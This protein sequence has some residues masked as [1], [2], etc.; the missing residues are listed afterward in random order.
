MRKMRRQ[1]ISDVTARAPSLASSAAQ[2]LVQ[3]RVEKVAVHLLPHERY[4]LNSSANF[5][6]W[7]SSLRQARARP[8]ARGLVPSLNSKDSASYSKNA[9]SISTGFAA[10]CSWVRPGIAEPSGF[11]R[12]SALSD[13]APMRAITSGSV[14]ELQN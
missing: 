4:R 2:T 9:P 5:P 7:G 10:P 3:Y 12:W 8:H 13:P 11:S 14:P 6:D 1:D